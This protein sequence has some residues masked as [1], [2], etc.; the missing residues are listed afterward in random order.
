M[1]ALPSLLPDID[2]SGG[3]TFHNSHPTDLYSYPAYASLVGD[4]FVFNSS[5]Y[6]SGTI[7]TA[8]IDGLDSDL[9]SDIY[10]TD[11]SVQPAGTDIFSL[12][13]FGN[14]LALEQELLAK[15]DHIYGSDRSDTI[16]GFGG[17]DFLYG[18]AGS[19]I[20]EGGPG[21]DA[22]NGGKGTDTAQYAHAGS[23]VVVDLMSPNHNKGEAAGDTYSSIEVLTGTPFSDKLSGDDNANSI[24][25]GSGGNNKLFGRG[26]NDTLLTLGGDDWLDGGPGHDNLAGGGGQDTYDFNSVNDSKPGAKRDIIQGFNHA[27]SDQIDLSTIDANTQKSGNQ[28]FVFIGTDTFK[29]YHN[30]HPDTI[31]M[32]RFENGIVQAN[33]NADLAPDL[34][35]AVIGVGSMTAGDF[36]L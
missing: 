12:M 29:H 6:V 14:Y 16:L 18:N 30:H 20:L 27:E 24:G 13:K 10:I 36:V 4:D 7:L 11:L 25:G 31:G 23:G 34:E 5:G 8:A 32:V 9:V 28:K 35:I 21:A 2:H 1:S 3:M 26:G 19:D 17:K 15:G 33:V 22:L